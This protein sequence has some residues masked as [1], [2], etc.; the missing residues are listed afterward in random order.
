MPSTMRKIEFDGYN[1]SVDIYR[2]LCDDESC[3][4]K[5]QTYRELEMFVKIEIREPR[6]RRIRSSLF[7]VCLHS[8]TEIHILNRARVIINTVCRLWEHNTKRKR[9]MRIVMYRLICE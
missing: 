2:S 5:R 9:D 4:L 7:L 8:K 1:T 3:E 6:P